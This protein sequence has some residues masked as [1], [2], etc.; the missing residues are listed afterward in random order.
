VKNSKPFASL[1]LT[2]LMAIGAGFTIGQEVVQ[3]KPPQF[4]PAWGYRCQQGENVNRPGKQCN[5]VNRTTNEQNISRD[6]DEREQNNRPNTWSQN[7]RDRHFSTERDQDERNE[8]N[9][10]N[11]HSQNER[12]RNYQPTT[13]DQDERDQNNQSHTRSQNET[14]RNNRLDSRQQHQIGKHQKHQADRNNR[15]SETEQKNHRS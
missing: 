13:R 2:C 3:A 4:A 10:F 11:T 5:Q 9:R 6:Q 12:D 15:Q 7:Q 8:N 14:D 1:S